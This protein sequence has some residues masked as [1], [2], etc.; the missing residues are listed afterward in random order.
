M[1]L[2]ICIYGNVDQCYW[3]NLDF[4]TKAC[5]R[6]QHITSVVLKKNGMSYKDFPPPEI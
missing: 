6:S 3:W 5:S 2:E 1:G 4:V